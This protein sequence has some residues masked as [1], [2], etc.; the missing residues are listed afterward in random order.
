[1]TQSVN[2]GVDNVNGAVKDLTTEGVID[3]M[4]T[5]QMYIKVATRDVRFV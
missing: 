1:M 5:T 4:V 2:I 3:L